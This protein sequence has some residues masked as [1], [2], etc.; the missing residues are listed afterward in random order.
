M[1]IER[2]G[3]FILFRKRERVGTCCQRMLGWSTQ[4]PKS[5]LPC[6][7]NRERGHGTVKS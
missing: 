3:D 4:Y 1:A 5:L 6:E 2:A 7:R